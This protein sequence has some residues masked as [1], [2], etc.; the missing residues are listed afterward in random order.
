[1]TTEDTRC[2]ACKGQVIGACTCPTSS[3]ALRFE[4]EALRA[5]GLCG[6]IIGTPPNERA[7]ILPLGH[8]PHGDDAQPK[9]EI[10]AA[11]CPDHKGNRAAYCS[12]C[13]NEA[14]ELAN[15]YEAHV[16]SQR[17]T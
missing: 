7:C 17:E 14:W 1:M 3:P 10:K 4:T 15:E 8:G 6:G 9:L 11:R 12:D 2:R 5:K 16:E 13:Q